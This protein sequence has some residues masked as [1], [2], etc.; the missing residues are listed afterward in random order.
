MIPAGVDR[1]DAYISPLRAKSLAGL[2]PAYVVTA[3]CDPLRDEGNAYADALRAAGVPV[4]SECFAGQIHG[5]FGNAHYFPEA[6]GA[7]RTAA[8]RLSEAFAAS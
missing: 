3:E 1:S 5:F 6:M 2:P 8:A 4:E 7:V